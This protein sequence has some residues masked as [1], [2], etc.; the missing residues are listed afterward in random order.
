MRI[1]VMSDTHGDMDSMRT[2]A[3]AM[4]NDHNV[5]AI[6]HLGDD[7]SD[8]NELIESGVAVYSV[9]GLFEPSYKN[10]SIPNRAIHEFN[11]VPFLLTH[12]V[13]KTPQD[14]IEDLDPKEIV[15]D[16]EVKVVLY[17][18]SHIYRISEER[19][20]IF[21]NPGHLKNGDKRSPRKTYAIV[22]ILATKIVAK[23]IDLGGEV[24]EERTF[25]LMD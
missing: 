13:V 14:P 23:I 25:F 18:H 11:G 4:L 5:E 6:V 3:V 24:V 10:P 22:D 20:V 19:G 12:S 2:A 8:A 15:D 21:I 17:G 9:P 16:D 7:S 1:G